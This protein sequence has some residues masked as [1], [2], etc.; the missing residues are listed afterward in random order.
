MLKLTFKRTVGLTAAAAL[1]LSGTVALAGSSQA[2]VAAIK[3]A[4]STGPSVTATYIISVTGKGFQDA[5]GDSVVTHVTFQSSACAAT[6][7]GTAAT[8]YSVTSATRM[9]VTTPSL[10][11]QAWN[12]CVY[13]GASNLVGAGK[14]TTYAAPTV[15]ANL[16]PTSGSNLGGGSVT[17]TGTNFTKKASVTFDGVPAK[18]VKY[19]SATKLTAVTPSHAAE[20]DVQVAVTTEG[21]TSADVAFDNFDFINSI[22]VSPQVGKPLTA[23]P[24]TVKGVG[25]KDTLASANA[26][27]GVVFTRAGMTSATDDLFKCTD[28][29]IVSDTEVVCKTPVG[30]TEGAW[31]VVV[32]KDDTSAVGGATDPYETGVSAGAAFTAAAF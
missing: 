29:Q 31:I 1:A 8:T 7:T 24:I 22:T 19:V 16:S 17:I 30:L 27:A 4:P 10:A 12:L 9:V 32:T 25:L 21:G 14:Y 20:D 26:N 23:T 5:A 3:V 11:A 18:S 28:V 13:A 2:A 6:Q 15:S